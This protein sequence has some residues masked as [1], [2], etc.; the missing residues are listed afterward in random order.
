MISE[1]SRNVI[2]VLAV[3]TVGSFWIARK[4]PEQER[5]PT[6]GLDLELDYALSEFEIQSFDLQ[7]TPAYLLRAPR[8]TSDSRTGEGHIDDPQIELHN[9]GFLWHIIADVAT[10][11]R[12]RQRVTLEG[13]VDLYR[14]GSKPTDWLAMSSSEVTLEITPR[15]AWSNQFVELMDSSSRLTATGFSVDMLNS[16]YRLQDDVK[17]NYAIQ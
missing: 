12:D 14:S 13:E 2:L 5:G 1:S 6:P 3:L 17:G 4:A 11:T 16:S 10:V 8:F 9:A 15:I 7:G